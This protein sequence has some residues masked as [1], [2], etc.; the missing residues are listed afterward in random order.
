VCGRYNIIPDAEAWA[1]AFDLTAELKSA[2]ADLAP[3]YNVAPTQS[4][5]ILR[6]SE[7]NGTLEMVEVRWGLIPSWAKNKS[8]G[9]KLINAR[10]ET[11]STKPAFRNSAKMRRCILPVNG[12]YE[13]KSL[14]DST[15]K[16][17]YLIAMRDQSPFAF[18]GLW[19]NWRDP[20]DGTN[21]QSCTILTTRA[22]NIM[23]SIHQ[24]MPVILAA[25]HL[26]AW[27]QTPIEGFCEFLKPSDS[28]SLSITPVSRYVNNPRNNDVRCIESLDYST[29]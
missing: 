23:A 2:V 10:S 4:V 19:E 13:W 3:S 12:F 11:V 26:K 29:E 5:P 9:Y 17:P 28:E 22:N 1:S 25:N 21:I 14:P 24:R 18:A 7:I 16:Q 27:L 8:I 15:V 6:N 20:S